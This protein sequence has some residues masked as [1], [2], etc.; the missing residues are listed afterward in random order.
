LQTFKSFGAEARFL[1]TWVSANPNSAPPTLF[2]WAS[3][4]REIDYDPGRITSREKH[5]NCSSGPKEQSPGGIVKNDPV[6]RE[7][8]REED[9]RAWF[10]R[11]KRG[12][13]S[14]P[15]ISD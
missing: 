1:K 11:Q 14:S 7:K 15:D 9:A 2:F 3:D 13:D 10:F 8:S 5:E 12:L 6:S 4:F